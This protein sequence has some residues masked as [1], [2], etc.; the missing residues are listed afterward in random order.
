MKAILGVVLAAGLVYGGW[1][2]FVHT[3]NF[4]PAIVTPT[5]NVRMEFS[6]DPAARLY[7]VTHEV[8][9]GDRSRRPRLIALT[10]DD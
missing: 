6:G 4:T 10:F 5:T 9:T 2:A 1:R 8:S 3:S 7:R